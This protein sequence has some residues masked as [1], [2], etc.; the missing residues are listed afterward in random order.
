MR[1]PPIVSLAVDP[2]DGFEDEGP[3]SAW[4]PPDDRLWR[5]PSEI[6]GDSPPDLD[7]PGDLE[8][9][10]RIGAGD[11]SDVTRDFD[12]HLRATHGSVGTLV[13]TGPVR[14]WA[15]AVVAGVVGAL[16]ASG[17]SMATRDFGS[18]APAVQ[19]TA[20]LV[21]P[22][23][24]ATPDTVDLAL[25]ESSPGVAASPNWTSIAS[26]IAAS[27]VGVV[28]SNGNAGSGV[29]YAEGNGKSYIL[30]TDDLATGHAQIT[31]NDGEQQ[32]A[33]F[34]NADP[35]SG[36]AI[37]SVAGEQRAIP[38][39]GSVSDLRDAEPV[40]AVTG[41]QPDL[42]DAP[43]S[44]TS[45]DDAAT[46]SDDQTLV[47]V[48]AVTGTA[49]T[50]E[51]GAL[52]DAEGRVIGITTSM[53]SPDPNEQGTSY[54]IPIDLAVHVANQLLD[55]RHV[56]HPYLGVIQAQDLSSI[57]AQSMGV[58]G[59]AT[60]ETVA[61]GSPAAAAG[62]AAGDVITAMGRSRVTSAGAF[63]SALFRFSPGASITLHYL[64][65]G[66]PASVTVRVSEQPSNINDPNGY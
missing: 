20:S 9:L 19:T 36:I 47:N 48:L 66:K 43:L 46:L 18:R 42:T 53:T 37:V 62:I 45:V 27:V 49:P 4:L 29:L 23:T 54:A 16:L 15:V 64:H 58:P 7:T 65:Q 11:N 30:T 55:R 35:A 5:H 39:F 21:T 56:T 22:E 40:L 24:V 8:A 34:V 1:R 14:T 51:G 32:S 44:V 33:K 3:F 60:V 41:G 25:P 17:V 6:G 57:T 2:D 13:R 31:F 52:V 26:A 63:V 12:A 10:A 28:A 59:G 38:T 50:S 61:P